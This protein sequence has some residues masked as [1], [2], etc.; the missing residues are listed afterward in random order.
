MNAGRGI[1]VLQLFA[2]EVWLA[3]CHH[4]QM[5]GRH[6]HQAKSR[7]HCATPRATI[8]QVLGIADDAR[9]GI[10]RHPDLR[11]QRIARA[12]SS[13]DHL[14]DEPQNAEDQDDHRAP[15]GVLRPP[16]V[17]AV[18]NTPASAMN[19]ATTGPEMSRTRSS[20]CGDQSSG[21]ERADSLAVTA[22]LSA[23]R[24]RNIPL[25]CIGVPPFCGSGA[26]PAPPG[27]VPPRHRPGQGNCP[28]PSPRG[29]YRVGRFDPP[30][31]RGQK[32][33]GAQLVGPTPQLRTGPM[34][35]DRSVIGPVRFSVWNID[36]VT[37]SSHRARQRSQQGRRAPRRDRS[38]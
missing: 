1:G 32:P 34:G 10:D 7:A 3:P 24:R 31:P 13:L 20:R 8:T 35:V 21:Q 9:A 18:Q 11:R 30:G 23:H 29:R 27:I 17:A 36:A 26:V 12:G 28:A 37:A 22:C 33:P 25:V 16:H 14:R 5:R 15:D 19:I 38:A 2:A 4:P 6:W